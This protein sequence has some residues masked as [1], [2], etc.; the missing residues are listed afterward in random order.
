M[1]DAT[2]KAVEFIQGRQRVD[3]DSDEKLALAVVRLL[4]ILGE[5]AK[6]ISDETRKRNPTIAWKEI[7]GT[8]N[9]LIHG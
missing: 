3:L 8:R 5:A 9:R 4:E 2:K 6:G 7:A 1:L